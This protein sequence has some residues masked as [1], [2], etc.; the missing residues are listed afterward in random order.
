V[1]KT[2]QRA[3]EQIAGVNAIARA[4]GNDLSS[5]WANPATQHKRRVNEYMIA[6][7]VT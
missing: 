3:Y 6:H 4:K 7:I 2:F 1:R 5:I